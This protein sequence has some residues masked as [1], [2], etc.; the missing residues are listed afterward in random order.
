MTQARKTQIS[1]DAT[2]YYHCINRCV[3]RAF[4]CGVDKFSGNNYE[5]RRGWIVDKLKSLSK[6]F[7]I[8]VCAYAVMNNHYHLVLKVD[9]DSAENWDTKQVLE[10][11]HE[12]FSGNQMTYDFVANKSQSKATLLRVEKYAKLWRT[13]LYDISWFMRCLNE[14]IARQANKEDGVKGRFWEGRF[15]SQALLDEEAILSCM[16]YV[17]LNPIR[18]GMADTPEASEFTSIQE[19]I[20][21]FQK[22][23]TQ[24]EDLVELADFDDEHSLPFGLKDYLELVD[25]SG[26]AIIKQKRAAIP[27]DIPP[28][29]HR[30][31]INPKQYLKFMRKNG[32]VHAIGKPESLKMLARDMGFKF[33]KGQR[34]AKKM[35]ACV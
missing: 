14:S 24:P 28:I 3:R 8:D 5:H 6:I 11:W 32:F 19:R 29:L 23:K 20:K 31:N 35:F 9:Q 12:L 27:P 30:L 13:R 25:W 1:L 33:I 7:A 22:E 17:D 10:L 2:P 18:A 21:A 34:Q 16:A 15:K 4:L 26:R